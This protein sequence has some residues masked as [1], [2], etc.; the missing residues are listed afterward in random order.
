MP[1][2]QQQQHEKREQLKAQLKQLHR[3]AQ[4]GPEHAH[5]QE[6]EQEQGGD[7][8]EKELADM[9]H[10][11]VKSTSAPGSPRW[12]LLVEIGRL[13]KR[14]EYPHLL[15]GDEAAWQ[16]LRAAASCPDGVV[17]G[18]AQLMLLEPPL[19]AED[20]R[21]RAM[22]TGPAELVTAAALRAIKATPSFAFHRPVFA[23]LARTREP[24]PTLV[25]KPA[26][27]AF[28][29]I[30]DMLDSP[31]QAPPPR[32]I[33]DRQNVHDHGVNTAVAR[34]LHALRAAHPAAV[35][36]DEQQRAL[37]R[38]VDAVLSAPMADL[39]PDEAARVKGDALAVLDRIGAETGRH[40]V[41]GVTEREVLSMV[42]SAIESG[43]ADSTD[44][45]RE[46]LT[47]QLA[48]GVERGSV[49]CST[50]RI[51][52]VVSALDGSG[53][54]AADLRPMWA[55]REEL[56][57]MAARIRDK[58]APGGAAAFREEATRLYVEELGLS[59]DLV[60]PVIAEYAEAI[61]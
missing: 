18:E 50:G 58:G 9:A 23:A 26:V 41:L 37:E 3:Q 43:P 46:T 16:V 38:S 51:A 7:R 27:A 55:V 44:G 13:Y 45:L 34:S 21:G 14:G 20:R 39:A 33:I 32:A 1:Q 19:A 42:W 61:E 12:S 48:S 30:I 47:K 15:P 53:R 40:S 59:R 35:K 10:A 60:A 52:R 36:S 8:L 49:V 29:D 4:E 56:G 28:E 22:R 5:E 6:L 57:T 31:Q 2:Q 24:T 54:L 17:A 11:F 25:T